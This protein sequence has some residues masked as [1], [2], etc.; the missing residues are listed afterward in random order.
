MRIV[1]QDLSDISKMLL[2]AICAWV[3]PQRHWSGVCYRFA[4][5]EL[6]KNQKRTQSVVERIRIACNGQALRLSP[7]E[8]E[9]ACRVAHYLDR[10]QV[11]AEYRPCGWSPEIQMHGREHLDQAL[12]EGRGAILWI[13]NF[14]SSSLVTK[15]AFH[16][17]RIDV[18]HLSRPTHGFSRTKFGIKYLNPIRTRIEDRY[19]KERVVIG[20]GKRAYA[21]QQLRQRLSENCVISTTVVQ[22]AKKLLAVPFL[23]ARFEFAI[24]SLRLAM[25]TG[26]PLLPVFTVCDEMGTYHVHL[27]PAIDLSPGGSGDET[28]EKALHDYARRLEHYVLRYPGLWRAWPQL[29]VN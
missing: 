8:V 20:P 14:A 11:F 13:G 25:T 16:R 9:L 3:L 1:R 26:A 5:A 28:Y 7:E 29:C 12:A 18:S 10:L 21:L 15:M 24:D 23:S 4:K 6:Y 22:E 2:L 27:G 19:L 17:A